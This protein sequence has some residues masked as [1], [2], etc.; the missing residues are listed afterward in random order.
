MKAIKPTTQDNRIAEQANVLSGGYVR[1]NIQVTEAQSEVLRRLSFERRKSEAELVREALDA[2]I[3][4][5]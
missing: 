4:K 1:K 5:Q 3:A 2:W